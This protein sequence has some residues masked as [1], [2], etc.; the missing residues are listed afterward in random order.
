MKRNKTIEAEA[1]TKDK[2]VVDKKKTNKIPTVTKKNKSLTDSK[3][4]KLAK[5]KDQE[6][7]KNTKTVEDHKLWIEKRKTKQRILELD[8]V[9]TDSPDDIEQLPPLDPEVEKVILEESKKKFEEALIKFKT[10][11]SVFNQ[12]QYPCPYE[13][14]RMNRW[15][16]RFPPELGIRPWFLK[17]S[18]R[19]SIKVKKNIFGIKKITYP[20]ITSVFRDPIGPSATQAIMELF[21]SG[22]KFDYQ[23]EMLDPTGVV[24][25]SWV[26]IGCSITKL[27]FGYLSMTE[28]DIVHITMEI[29]PSKIK[30]N[31]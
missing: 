1:K 17:E 16:L 31:F 27:D 8:E 10:N 13:P 4:S 9:L 6:K 19:P 15:I 26:I 25:E 22:K 12:I 7:D 29:E 18:Q 3:T 30:L 14:K 11:D 23:L 5:V 20:A 2:L 28:D 24:V 21:D